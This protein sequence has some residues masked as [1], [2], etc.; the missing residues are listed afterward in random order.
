MHKN[1]TNYGLGYILGDF[2]A[3]IGRLFSL[4]H[5]VALT[6]LASPTFKRRSLVFMSNDANVTLT[7]EGDAAS[8]K[9]ADTTCNATCDSTYAM[10][11]A[12]QRMRC[13]VRFNV[14]VA[15]CAAQR[16]RCNVR[17]N[18]CDSTCGA[19]YAIQRMRCNCGE[20]YA[21]Q[22]AMQRTLPRAAQGPEQGPM[23]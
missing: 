8:I 10:Q 12:I 1:L 16:M 15:T 6:T 18:E 17:R 9:K 22:R 5:L 14:C 23:L 21:V 19:T 3:A 11:R 13:N 4:K 7:F 20:T 2:L